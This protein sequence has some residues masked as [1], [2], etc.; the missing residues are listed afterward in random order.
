M[1]MGSGSPQ[2]P[3]HAHPRPERVTSSLTTGCSLAQLTGGAAPLQFS[4]LWAGQLPAHWAL[5]WEEEG[6]HIS[7]E[8]C[9]VEHSR[10]AAPFT[11]FLPPSRPRSP[12]AARPQSTGSP[13]SLCGGGC[14]T[15]ALTHETRVVLTACKGL[16]TY[17]KWSRRSHARNEK[18]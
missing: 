8:R 6:G 10:Q 14:A 12:S 15:S 3:S 1:V 11:C 4:S 13:L 2:R 18:S 17:V 5:A 7:P 9:W 16:A